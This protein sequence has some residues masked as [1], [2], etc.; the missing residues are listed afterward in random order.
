[1][2]GFGFGGRCGGVALCSEVPYCTLDIFMQSPRLKFPFLT[3]EKGRKYVHNLADSLNNGSDIVCDFPDFMLQFPPIQ[4]VPCFQFALEEFV[5]QVPV[6]DLFFLSNEPSEGK[7]SLFS[8]KSSIRKRI[9]LTDKPGG[10]WGSSANSGTDSGRDRSGEITISK[11]TGD[12]SWSTLVST[13]REKSYRMGAAIVV[14]AL[15]AIVA[16][17]SADEA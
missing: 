1:L 5:F 2:C 7:R 13:R 15:K 9:L 8:S 11:F 4:R 6:K 14:A 12:N 3:T 10:S 16:T 17:R